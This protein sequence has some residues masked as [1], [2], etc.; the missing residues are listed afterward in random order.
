VTEV[1]V[2]SLQFKRSEDMEML[3][4]RLERNEIKKFAFATPSHADAFFHLRERFE[5]QE[6]K[7]ILKGVTVAVLSD[8]TKDKL[9]DYGVAVDIIPEKATAEIMVMDVAD[10]L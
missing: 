6:A 9:E 4:D 3:L 1:P 10:A 7:D 8:D 2:C 5:D